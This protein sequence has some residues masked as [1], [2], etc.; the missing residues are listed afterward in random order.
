[1]ALPWDIESSW[2]RMERCP[3][4]QCSKRQVGTAEFSSGLGELLWRNVA[5]SFPEPDCAC[6]GKAF[7]SISRYVFFIALGTGSAKRFSHRYTDTLIATPIHRYTNA[8]IAVRAPI[9]R[10][11]DCRLFRVWVWFRV[12]FRAGLGFV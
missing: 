5:T 11:T 6:F 8:P 10:Y 2:K 9:H 3:Q 12:S 1:M 4:F 7:V